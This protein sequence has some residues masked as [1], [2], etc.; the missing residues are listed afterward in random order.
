VHDKQVRRRRAVLALL[1]CASLILLTAYFGK[2]SSSPLHSAQRGIAEVMS[3]IQ[4][5]AST[6]LSPVRDVAGWVSST[7]NAKSE[8]GRLTRE[9]AT[10]KGELAQALYAETQVKRLSA[11]VKLDESPGVNIDDYSPVAAD[12]IGYDPSLWYQQIEVDKGSDDGVRQGDPVVGNDG[13]V[14]DVSTVSSSV[15]YV[16]ELTDDKFGAGAE[17]VPGGYPGVLQPQAGNSGLLLTYLPTNATGIQAGDEVVT[18]GFVDSSDSSVHSNFPP[19][20]PIGQVSS[21]FNEGDLINNQQVPITPA[22]NLRNLS[23]VQILTR[24]YPAGTE[25]ASLAAP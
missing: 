7:F 8:N 10:L 25:H 14:G 19:G 23:V 24:P 6:V 18:D 12:V 2:S 21:S 17:I 15:S 3:P 11:L 20:I 13:L 1:V 16:T 22:V 5:G 9:N 4:N